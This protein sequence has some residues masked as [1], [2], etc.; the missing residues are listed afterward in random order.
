MSNPLPPSVK[1]SISSGW[2]YTGG[3]PT[4]AILKDMRF[5]M[6][7]LPIGYSRV[8]SSSSSSRLSTPW[9]VLKSILLCVGYRIPYP[10]PV[11]HDVQLLSSVTERRRRG[12]R[13]ASKED[14]SSRW[15]VMG[16]VSLP[17]QGDR[18]RNRISFTGSRS[19]NDEHQALAH[20]TGA[21]VVSGSVA[22]HTTSGSIIGHLRIY[23]S[24]YVLLAE[25]LEKGTVLRGVVFFTTWLSTPIQ[26]ARRVV[27]GRSEL[28]MWSA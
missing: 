18:L 2:T 17:V 16:L 5:R 10:T 1:R 22:D 14:T 3:T 21:S 19:V 13:S 27:I 11:K 23:G 7:L 6:A 15:G 26:A 9:R 12:F 28:D 20:V 24:S 8:L 25:D 4:L